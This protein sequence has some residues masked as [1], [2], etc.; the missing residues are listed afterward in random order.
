VLGMVVT[1]AGREG[2]LGKTPPPAAAAAGSGAQGV[3][4]KGVG[5]ATKPLAAGASAG[6][7][8]AAQPAA[9]PAPASAGRE[10][11]REAGGAGSAGGAG[12]EVS[13]ERRN[14]IVQAYLSHR[15]Q[16]AFDL[17]GVAE[18]VTLPA[19]E[20]AYL[21][22]AERFAPWR[23]HGP[24]L[25]TTAEKARAVF[26]AGARA[27]A[28]LADSEQ[29]NTLLLR[30]QTLRD[31]LRRR[32]PGDSFGIKTDLLDPEVQFKKGR[33]LIEAGRYREAILQLEFA[34]DCDPQNGLYGAEL[35][36]CRFLASPAASSQALE[37]LQETLRRDP[38]YGI[39]LF[40]SG[41]IHR[42]LGNHDAAEAL[43]RRALKA[44]S[45][46]RRP[47]QAL[48]ALAAERRR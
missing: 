39:A 27:F 30:R 18:G 6:V 13:E 4:A 3:G 28:E 14:E 43:L 25:E 37:E 16:D 35:A 26:L 34:S 10:P 7:E 19:L 17:L 24:Q 2:V 29:R 47:I 41:E 38:D 48:K 15:Q 23:L 11:G 36:Y 20:A 32:G 31:E 22:F 45:P 46:D 1:D 9:A 12:G 5:V 33:A 44:M 42:A 21:A 40:Y 8:R